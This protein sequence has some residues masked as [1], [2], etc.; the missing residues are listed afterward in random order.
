MVPRRFDDEEVHVAASIVTECFDA[1]P[2]AAWT[3]L[4]DFAGISDVFSAVSDV[5]V[6]GDVRSFTLFGMRIAERLIRRDEETHTLTYSIIEGMD[7]EA[8]EATIHVAPAEGGCEVTW[9]VTTTPEAA[10]PLFSDTYARALTSLHVTL[11]ATE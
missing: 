7:V 11:D 6:D 9:S 10:Q 4:G 1:P 5:A 2:E 3:L 8:H